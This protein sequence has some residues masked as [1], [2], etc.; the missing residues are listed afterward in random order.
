MSV[1]DLFR[2]NFEG[3]GQ[4]NASSGDSSDDSSVAGA[5]LAL[6]FDFSDGKSKL[7]CKVKVK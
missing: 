5:L 2:G 1:E 6:C 4:N 3:E 7:K